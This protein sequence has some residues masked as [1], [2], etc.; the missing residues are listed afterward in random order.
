[1]RRGKNK[2]ALVLGFPLFWFA[3]E[4]ERYEQRRDLKQDHKEEGNL[5]R[6]F[7]VDEAS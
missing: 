3:Y 2:R 5:M 4:E 6:D 1:M 7:L